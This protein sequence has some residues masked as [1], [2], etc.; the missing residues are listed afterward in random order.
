MEPARY[1]M[2]FAGFFVLKA[3]A[4]LFYIDYTFILR[5]YEMKNL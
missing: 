2:Y 4:L 3:L 1:V 5:K